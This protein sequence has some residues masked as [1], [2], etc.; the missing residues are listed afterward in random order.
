MYRLTANG[1]LV[2]LRVNEECTDLVRGLA[3]FEPVGSCDLPGPRGHQGDGARRQIEENCQRE[4]IFVIKRTKDGS[5]W[6]SK[7]V[8]KATGQA[9][10]QSAAGTLG[11][12][13]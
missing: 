1:D 13:T 9:Q 7:V 10:Q 12:S 6:T 5:N 8:L 3:I 2:L 11:E 4:K